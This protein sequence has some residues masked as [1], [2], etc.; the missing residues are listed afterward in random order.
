M[1]AAT[2]GSVATRGILDGGPGVRLL[3]RHKVC[4][5]CDWIYL[6]EKLL[7]QEQIMSHTVLHVTVMFMTSLALVILF[8]TTAAAQLPITLPAPVTTYRP[9][10]PAPV[11]TT[12]RPV[13]PAPVVT[14]YRPVVPAPV[15]TTYRPVVPAPVVTRYRPVVPAP[16]VTTYRPVYPTVVPAVAPVVVATDV[17]VPGQPIRNLLRAITP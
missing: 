4:S 2:K 10:V 16:V 12:Y 13:V 17:Y 8:A 15:V 7:K 1:A 5:P 9:V 3:L 11:V 6:P 14:T